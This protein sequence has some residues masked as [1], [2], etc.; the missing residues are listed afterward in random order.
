MMMG[1][2]G[3]G[4]I[5]MLIF[6]VVVV[7]L[8]VWLLSELFPRIRDSQSGQGTPQHIQ[9]SNTALDILQGRYARSEITKEEYDRIRQDLAT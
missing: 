2:G 3:F 7:G 5:F 4:M 8:A 9:P 6:W 1:F